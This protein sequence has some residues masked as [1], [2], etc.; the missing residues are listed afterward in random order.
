MTKL[1]TNWIYNDQAEANATPGR[2]AGD[3]YTT[4][5]GHGFWDGTAGKFPV[6]QHRIISKG[7]AAGTNIVLA[8]VPIPIG[9]AQIVSVDT[10]VVDPANVNDY[11]FR[12]EEWFIVRDDGG[13]AASS[14]LLPAVPYIFAGGAG[15]TWGLTYTLQAANLRILLTFSGAA[16]LDAGVTPRVSTTEWA[17]V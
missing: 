5:D 11:I 4:L 3:V 15:S 1:N 16:L 14:V 17:G 7:L 6:G 10:V 9:S 13:G 2:V 12:R 8:D